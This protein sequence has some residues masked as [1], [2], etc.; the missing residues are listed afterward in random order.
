LPEP[1][2]ISDLALLETHV[3]AAGE[4]ARKFFGGDCRHWDKS[5]G[6]PVTEADLAID[7][8]LMEN[9][10]AARAD[11]GW[12]S[13]ESEDDPARLDAAKVFMVDPID[14][15]IAFVKGRPHFSI[16]AG[17]VR[18]GQP[19]A[20]V[21]YN[22]ISEEFFSARLGGG[23][24]LN[25]AP[26]HV[27]MRQTVEGCAMLGARTMFDN[28]AWSR[29]PFTPWPEMKI[30]NRN[31]V[32]YRM[33]LV[34]AGQWDAMLALS[35]KRDWDLAAAEIICREAGGIVSSHTGAPLVYNSPGASH[36]SV[37][38]AGPDLHARLLEFLKPVMLP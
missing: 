10:R 27:S 32:A 3:R 38:A 25:G 9:L 31:S 21:V 30:E 11:Y 37:V 33:A 20:G 29:P 8:F 4:I 28:P 5:A 35:A 34:A 1:D 13:E 14:G 19:Y 15:T 36:P 7:K 16:C 24:Q 23:A 12:L 22:P 2:D 17:L 26:I 6:Q 18:A